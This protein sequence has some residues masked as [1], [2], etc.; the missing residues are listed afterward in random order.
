LTRTLEKE[1]NDS[2]KIVP[3]NMVTDNRRELWQQLKKRFPP[4]PLVASM[5]TDAPL[6]KFPRL[7]FQIIN[8]FQRLRQS[9]A[10][11]K[12]LIRFK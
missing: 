4:N 11:N 5:Y 2:V 12:V 9:A 6:N 3:I 1:W 7:P 8:M 10:R